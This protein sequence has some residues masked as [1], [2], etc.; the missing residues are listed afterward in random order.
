MDENILTNES[1]EEE[2]S[3][4]IRTPNAAQKNMGANS[5]NV[6]NSAAFSNQ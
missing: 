6:I 1:R 4:N 2:E 3:H 5:I